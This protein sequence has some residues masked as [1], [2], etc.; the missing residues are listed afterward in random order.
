MATTVLAA[1][2][3]DDG[4]RTAGS[5]PAKP[6]STTTTTVSGAVAVAALTVA[7][8]DAAATCRLVPEKT[9]GPF[10]LDRQLDR[11]NITE[12][13]PGRPL[14]LGLHVVDAHC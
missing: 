13:L 2:S 3:S 11:R 12:N 8:F 1:C 14:R 9:A 5:S 4:G 6:T 7:D 10:P